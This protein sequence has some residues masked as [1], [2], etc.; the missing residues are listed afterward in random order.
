MLNWNGTEIIYNTTI[1][2]DKIELQMI[3]N[4]IASTQELINTY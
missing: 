2:V 3:F 1:Q 4:T